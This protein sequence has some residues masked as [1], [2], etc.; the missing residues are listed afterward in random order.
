LKGFF[1]VKTVDRKEQLSMRVT[2]IQME[3]KDGPKEEFVL[4]S[5]AGN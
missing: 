5:N 2:R 1:S 3:I 4:I